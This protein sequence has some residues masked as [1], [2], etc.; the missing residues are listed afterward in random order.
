MSCVPVRDCRIG[1][2]R[3][4]VILPIVERTE[5]AFP[6]CA[7]IVWNGVSIC[8][9]QPLTPGQWCAAW[10]SCGSS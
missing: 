7:P 3:P 2:G 5:A 4:K 6:H 1:E 8:L 9:K 10:Q